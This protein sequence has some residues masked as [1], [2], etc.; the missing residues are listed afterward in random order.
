MNGSQNIADLEV[1]MH[2]LNEC[3]RLWFL[4][5]G[6]NPDLMNTPEVIVYGK[7]HFLQ[8]RN[9]LGNVIAKFEVTGPKVRLV[10]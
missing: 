10:A 7:S 8:W 6:Y 4:K 5:R 3:R 2:A 1:Y 9:Q